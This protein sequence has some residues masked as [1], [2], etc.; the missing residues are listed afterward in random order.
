M[1][2]SYAHS[3]AAISWRPAITS[4]RTGTALLKATEHLQQDTPVACGEAAH[5][6]SHT[7]TSGT[8]LRAGPGQATPVH[9]RADTQTEL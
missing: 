6:G 1:A 3:S 2:P 4:R 7:E 9:T 8:G 5:T